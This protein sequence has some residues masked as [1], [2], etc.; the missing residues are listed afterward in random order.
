MTQEEFANIYPEE[1]ISVFG[2][3]I[4]VEYSV[5]EHDHYSHLG[6]DYKD[7]HRLIC[8]LALQYKDPEALNFIKGL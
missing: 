2:T 1:V 5:R 3:N 7:V 4:T 6:I 8:K